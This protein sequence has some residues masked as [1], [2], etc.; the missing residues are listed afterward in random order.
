M[1]GRYPKRTK[2]I[3]QFILFHW[4][5][6]RNP[7]QLYGLLIVLL[8]LTLYKTRSL[9]KQ[10][11]TPSNLTCRWASMGKYWFTSRRR[12]KFS[13]VQIYACHDP[14]LS[15]TSNIA[16]IPEVSSVNSCLKQ[17][18]VSTN[19]VIFDIYQK[20]ISTFVFMISC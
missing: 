9:W 11:L 1:P 17:C 6:R 5:F 13:Q 10:A 16:S 7:G 3:S 4:S 12:I 18:I 15:T 2:T 14:Y 19:C 8:Y 20:L